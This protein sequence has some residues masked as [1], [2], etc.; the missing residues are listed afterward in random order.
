MIRFKGRQ[1]MKVYVKHKPVKWGFKS[2]ALCDANNAYNPL[3]VGPTGK[4]LFYDMLEIATITAFK[5]VVAWQTLNPGQ[6]DRPATYSQ[7]D[8]RE[9]LVR[10]LGGLSLCHCIVR[11]TGNY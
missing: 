4:V 7:Y 10:Q 11:T 2:Y 9:K 3:N 1:Q 5:L 8:F 6:I